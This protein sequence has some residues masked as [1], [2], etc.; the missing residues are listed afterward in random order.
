ME[1]KR[2]LEVWHFSMSRQRWIRA[3]HRDEE[4][5]LE[6]YIRLKRMG[7]KAKLP[8]PAHTGLS[9]WDRVSTFSFKKGMRSRAL[10]MVKHRTLRMLVRVTNHV[11][12]IKRR[13]KHAGMR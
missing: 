12:R 2:R 7:R 10:V 9:F 5:A 13:R 6:H 11:Q 1:M 4:T 8:Q 3:L